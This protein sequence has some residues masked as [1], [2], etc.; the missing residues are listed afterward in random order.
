MGTCTSQMT[1]IL[2]MYVHVTTKDASFTGRVQRKLQHVIH[3]QAASLSNN[4]AWTPNQYT[5]RVASL[6][7][8]QSRFYVLNFQKNNCGVKVG[9]KLLRIAVWEEIGNCVLAKWLMLAKCRT[10]LE[11]FDEIGKR[12]NCIFEKSLQIIFGFLEDIIIY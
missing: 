6:K 12:G 1:T 7:I 3:I 4:V 9:K 2:Y 10:K 5:C 8:Q 11:R